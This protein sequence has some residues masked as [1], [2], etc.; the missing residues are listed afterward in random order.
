MNDNY[1]NQ[2]FSFIWEED[3]IRENLQGI[4]KVKKMFYFLN[5]VVGTQMLLILS[6]FNTLHIN[7]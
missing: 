7:L 6:I 1:K 4:S 2:D 3:R 5:W